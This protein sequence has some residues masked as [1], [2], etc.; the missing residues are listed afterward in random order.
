M[1]ASN[2]ERSPLVYKR[3]WYQYSLR[4]LLLLVTICAI[5]CSWLAVKINQGKR[6]KAAVEALRAKG[7]FISYDYEVDRNGIYLPNAVLNVPQ[8]L[9]S[10]LG[11]DCFA[12]V[13]GVHAPLASS[14]GGYGYLNFLC[15]ATEDDLRSMAELSHVK[16]LELQGAQIGDSALKRIQNLSELEQ[17]GLCSTKITDAGLVELKAFPNLGKLD[18]GDT[19][20]TDGGMADLMC[21]GRLEELELSQTQVTDQGLAMLQELKTLKHLSFM[22]PFRTQMQ[23]SD[24]AVAKFKQAVPDCEVKL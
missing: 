12:T 19:E 5:L 1:D 23:I 18:L 14:F 20:V 8:W 15:S 24:E 2:Q 22:Q 4:S 13:V 7:F 10:W 11:D 3:R 6:Q 21:L 9:R 16:F 17:L